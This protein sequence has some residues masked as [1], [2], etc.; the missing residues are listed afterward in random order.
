MENKNNDLKKNNSNLDDVLFNPNS[1]KKS[2]NNLNKNKQIP[3]KLPKRK[4]NQPKKIFTG[5]ILTILVLCFS[6]VLAFGL[7]IFGK[8]VMGLGGNDNDIYINIEDGETTDDIAEKLLDENIIDNTIFFK[9]YTKFRKVDTEFKSGEHRLTSSMPYSELVK[10][11]QSSPYGSSETITLTFKEGITLNQVA[12]MLEENNVCSAEDFLT[13]FNKADSGFDFEELVPDNPLKFN[14]MEGYC[15]PDTIDFYLESPA[16]LVVQR[17]RQIFAEKVYSKYYT[18]MSES[19]LTFDQIITLASMVQAEAPNYE[20]MQMVASVFYN[21][22]KDSNA[23][24]KLQSDPTK[25]YVAEVIKPNLYEKNE[26]M[27]NAYNTYI[28]DGLPPGAICN[29]G[30]DAIKAVLNP[31][32]TDYYYFCANIDTKEIYYAKTK[33]QH[34]ANLVKANLK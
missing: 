7:I 4:S 23:Y 8:D 22:L 33:E 20:D 6:V 1:P 32:D 10:Q 11:L 14:R 15:Y 13:E 2:V 28:G 16:T 31:A 19:D 17:F 27:C 9:L 18:Q 29:P 25:K 12:T 3:Q 21:R 30:E 5:I 24:P 34:D 26:E